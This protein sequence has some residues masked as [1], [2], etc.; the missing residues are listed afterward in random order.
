MRPEE[1]LH[2][3]FEIDSHTRRIAVDGR[4]DS[5]HMRNLAGACPA[6]GF[7]AGVHY[8]CRHFRSDCRD[9]VRI[10]CWSA[11]RF[12]H[13]VVLQQRQF[14]QRFLR[15]ALPRRT[16]IFLQKIFIRFLR[17][18]AVAELLALQLS[19]SQHGVLA[20]LVRGIFVHEELVSVRR[21]LVVRPPKAVAHLGVE[22]RDSQ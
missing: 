19:R 15:F 1:Y 3:V 4:A 16:R 8:C 14:R 21:R 11:V 22:F 9:C 2:A 7:S 6:G 10:A 18:R 5:P 13:V 12:G 20:I 17:Q